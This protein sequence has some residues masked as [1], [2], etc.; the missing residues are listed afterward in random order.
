[1]PVSYSRC[2][3]RL[4]RFIRPGFDTWCR[5]ATAAGKKRKCSAAPVMLHRRS[6]ERHGGSRR[7]IGFLK[8]GLMIYWRYP[9]TGFLNSR[10]AITASPPDSQQVRAGFGNLWFTAFAEDMSS[11]CGVQVGWKIL[12]YWSV[13]TSLLV[14]LRWIYGCV[15]I[16]ATPHEHKFNPGTHSRM[17]AHIFSPENAASVYFVT[18][19]ENHDTNNKPLALFDNHMFHPGQS[20]GHTIPLSQLSPPSYFPLSL[21]LFGPLHP[22]NLPLPRTIHVFGLPLKPDLFL[23]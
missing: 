5:P 2:F 1:M 8:S 16:F 23:W 18:E 12:V 9:V 13:N 6:R 7:R 20:R 14:F 21:S 17:K 3:G 19:T 10:R 11:I 4:V 15:A 22:S